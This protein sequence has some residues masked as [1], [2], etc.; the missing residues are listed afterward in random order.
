MKG[1]CCCRGCG[2]PD[3]SFE[4]M[5]HLVLLLLGVP[6]LALLV[7]LPSMDQDVVLSLHL[8]NRKMP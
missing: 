8:D 3:R 2:Q 7:W 4:L 1:R 5:S 6:C